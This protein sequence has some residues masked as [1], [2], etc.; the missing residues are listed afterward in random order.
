[1][2]IENI[3]QKIIDINKN[4]LHIEDLY[5]VV[6][7]CSLMKIEELK[8]I[9]YSYF[10][11][12]ITALV[13]DGLISKCGRKTNNKAMELYLKYNINLNKEIIKFTQEDL[14]FLA[15]LNKKINADYYRKNIEAFYEDKYYIKIFND[16]LNELDKGNHTEMISV[17]ERSYQLFKDEKII[18]GGK[19]V[20]PL[21]GKVLKR[22]KL[23]Y[24]DIGCRDNYAPLLIL[25][26]PTFFSKENRNILIIENLDTYWTM[27]RLAM[28]NVKFRSMFDMLI[29]GE[30]NAI[31]GK[32]TNYD[33]Y[34][35][36]DKDNIFYF[37]DIDNHGLYIYS[38]F[39]EGFKNLNIRLAVQLYELMIDLSDIDNLKHVRTEK[40]SKL[41]DIY[42]DNIIKDFTNDY[43]LKLKYILSMNKYIPQEVLHYENLSKYVQESEV[44]LLE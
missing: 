29:Y 24:E 36:C 3:K 9:E 28:D 34:T 42:L 22:L 10:Y 7:E 4:R 13:E 8:T 31:T 41:E 21:A 18:K 1:M 2:N 6:S 12:C 32:F 38:N 27:N 11:K 19:D 15:V 37:G 40:Q 35:I 26:L 25:T 5:I 44:N 14:K 30:G 20:E 16:F 23:E 39:K 33:R 43:G 17:N